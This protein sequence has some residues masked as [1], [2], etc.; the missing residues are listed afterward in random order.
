[1]ADLSNGCMS[2]SDSM[3]SARQKPTASLISTALV[4]SVLTLSSTIRYASAT[5][6]II[7]LP[8]SENYFET[9]EKPCKVVILMA[10]PTNGESTFGVSEATEEC[11]VWSLSQTSSLCVR[12]GDRT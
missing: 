8:G 9:F 10:R 12:Y 6:I 7:H 5:P 2:M 3:Y 4:G 11:S 1:M